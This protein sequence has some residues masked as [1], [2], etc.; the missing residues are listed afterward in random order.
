V[1]G[2]E[3]S[4]AILIRGDRLLV[5]QRTKPSGTYYALVG[6]GIE[7]GE[8][9]ETALRRELLEETGLTVGS[10]QPVFTEVAN[11]RFGTQY[12]FLCE[13]LGGE[14]EL[15]ADSPEA[16]ENGL[17]QNMHLPMWLPL[18]EF[19]SV[20]FRSEGLR[21]ALLDALQHGFPDEPVELA[22]K[23]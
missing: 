2:R 7:T 20:P 23:G 1:P 10:V 14:P 9:P 3:A 13:Y 15:A 12:V 21:E 22:W 8:D 18:E 4:R 17:G 19:R 6:G 5:M 11:E 16:I